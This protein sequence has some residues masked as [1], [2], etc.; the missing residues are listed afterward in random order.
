MT[1]S[2]LINQIKTEGRIK[3]DDAFTPVVI[4]LMNEAY[5]EAVESQRPFE[6]REEVSIALTA[7]QSTVP[8]PSDFFIHH[9]LF[10]QTGSYAPYQLTDQDK[11]A[12]PAPRG[13]YGKPKQ[14]EIQSGTP[15]QIILKPT[16]NIASGDTL[17][18]IYY[19]A[20]TI[21]TSTNLTSPNPIP[22]LEPFIIRMALRRVRMYHSDDIQIAQMLT[23][24][25]SSAAN[26]YSKDSPERESTTGA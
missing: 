6:L 18:L 17:D 26:A 2:D 21:V 22:R 9:Q 19:Q 11:A 3:D 13:L 20:P 10:Y 15:L 24:D 16:T 1:F 12:S 4:G 5:K 8:V 25:I 14:F 23:G 7:N